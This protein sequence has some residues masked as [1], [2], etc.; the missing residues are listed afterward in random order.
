MK[1]KHLLPALLLPVLGLAQPALAAQSGTWG[2]PAASMAGGPTSQVNAQVRVWNFGDAGT[3]TI[4]AVRIYDANG[5]FY[6]VA[7]A[8][9][10]LGAHQA[11]IIQLRQLLGLGDESPPIVGL[12]V[13]VEWEATP[14]ARPWAEAIRTVYSRDVPAGPL[15][16]LSSDFIGCLELK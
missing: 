9:T 12:Q 3:L 16:L 1:A 14:G 8:P 11:T 10:P 4:R 13:L 6:P 2:C 5:R 7:Y 15:T